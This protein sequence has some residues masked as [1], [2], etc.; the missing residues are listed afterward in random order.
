MNIYTERPEG[1]QPESLL[2][3]EECAQTESTASKGAAGAVGTQE[4][5]R[6][7]GLPQRTDYD[8]AAPP[9][10]GVDFLAQ[11]CYEFQIQLILHGDLYSERLQD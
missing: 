6:Q 4:R 2:D 9:G 1:C 10:R 5:K 7:G 11:E 8:F 3:Q